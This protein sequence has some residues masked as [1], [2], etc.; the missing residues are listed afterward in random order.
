MQ[1]LPQGVSQDAVDPSK[2]DIITT[3]DCS[4]LIERAVD[5]LIHKLG[6]EFI[7]AALVCAVFLWQLLKALTSMLSSK[8]GRHRHAAHVI[9]P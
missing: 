9:E 3:Y 1:H 6:E 4:A 8:G 7:V 5:N 2:A